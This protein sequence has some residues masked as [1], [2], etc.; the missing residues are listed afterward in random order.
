[1]GGAGFANSGSTA[2]GGLTIIAS[3]PVRVSALGGSGRRSLC[4]AADRLEKAT[5]PR[6]SIAFFAA[7]GLMAKTSATIIRSLELDV[8][9]ALEPFTRKPVR[10]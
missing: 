4:C 7:D 6:T 5:M 10:L 2:A 1:L 8:P 3:G 9:H